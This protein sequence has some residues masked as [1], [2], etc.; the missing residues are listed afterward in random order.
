MF[1]KLFGY[2]VYML[3]TSNAEHYLSIR[4]VF[5]VVDDLRNELGVY[6]GPNAVSSRLPRIRTPNLNKLAGRSLLF[7]HA[8]CQFA[9]CAPSRVSVL[10]SRRPDT[11]K[12]GHSTVLGTVICPKCS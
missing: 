11:T 2:Q 12:G 9:L 5:A 10:T 4:M 1:L 8:Y 7:N 3:V 6:R